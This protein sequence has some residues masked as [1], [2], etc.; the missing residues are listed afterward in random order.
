MNREKKY[1]NLFSDSLAF[2][3][4]NFASKILVFLLIPLYTSVLTTRDYGIADLLNNTVNVLYPILTLSIMESTLRFACDKTSDKE[5]VLSNS[6]LLIVISEILVLGATPIVKYIDSGIYSYWMWFA[7]IFGGFNLHQIVT[8]YAKGIGKTKIF[9]ISGVIHTLIII[10]SNIIG[11]LI[12]KMGLNAYL[13]S[14]VLGYFLTTIYIV[15]AAKIKIKKW[16]INISLLKKMLL[17]SIPTIPTIIAWWVSVSADK[18]IIIAYLG[19]SMSGIYSVAY[20]I[21]SIM[22]LFTNIFSSAWTI[23]VIQNVDDKDNASYQT[24]VYKYF[25]IFN[26]LFCSVLILFSEFLGKI[27]FAKDFYI[28]WKCVP[29]LLVAYLFSGLSGFLASSF[30]AAKYT[31]GL[32]FSTTLGAL[33]NIILNFIVIKHY[34]IMGAAVTTMLGFAVTFYMR[35]QTIKKIVDIKMNLLKDSIAYLLLIIQAV[36]IGNE[37]RYGIIIGITILGIVFIM[38]LS[39]INKLISKCIPIVKKKMSRA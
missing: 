33:V 6:L 26:V 20:K 9:A 13:T 15:V 2:M 21:P 11:L 14:I 23:S 24:T 4:S 32:L 39:D 19:V 10:I 12:L 25:V 38:Y 27:L 30:R 7:A 22:T 1:K 18:Y 5:E 28:A 16:H 35:S 8:Q 17:F 37:I 3:I 34:G 36:V 31:K 29:M